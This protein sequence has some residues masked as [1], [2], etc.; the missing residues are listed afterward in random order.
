MGVCGSSHGAWNEVQKILDEENAGIWIQLVE[1]DAY[2]LPNDGTNLSRAIKLLE[3]AGLIQVDPAAG[4]TPELKDVTSYLYNIEISPVAANTLTSTLED[5]AASTVNGTYA[6]PFGLVP[7]KDALLTET[8]SEGEDNP[9]VNVIVSRT[10]DKDDPIYKKI[11]DAYR[12]QLVAEFTL[13]FNH[14]SSV[15]VFDYD[16]D[17]QAEEDFVNSILSYESPNRPK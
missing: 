4:Y 1:F 17:Y 3:T 6:V 8:Q 16:A 2:N 14:G 13:E 15:P 11:V 9:Y 7:S 5:Y 12:T 10:E